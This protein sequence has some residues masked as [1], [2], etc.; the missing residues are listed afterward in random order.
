MTIFERFK[1]VK[2]FAFDV[3]GV[4]TN[5]DV[6]VNEAGEQLRTFNIKDGYALQLAIK[7]GYPVLIVSG[8]NS[9]GVKLRFESLGVKDVFINESDKEAVLNGWIKEKK[10][11]LTDVLFMGDDV[12]DLAVMETIGF[13]V[14]PVDAIEDIKSICHYISSKKGGKGAVRDVIEKVMR[15]Q[16]TW[17]KNPSIKSM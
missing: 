11:N 16:G 1:R 2:A 6:L 14:C 9:K 3:D 8:G 4:F 10:L 7:H 17:T 15:L 5:G 12:P 13:P